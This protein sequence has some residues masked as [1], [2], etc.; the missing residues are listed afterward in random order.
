M[1]TFLSANIGTIVVGLIVLGIVAANIYNMIKKKKSGK[2]I[3]CGCGCEN[4]P[5]HCK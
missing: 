2:S 3:G 1:L 5:G 4:C